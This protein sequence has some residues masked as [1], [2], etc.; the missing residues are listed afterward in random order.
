MDSSGSMKPHNGPNNYNNEKQFVK[1]MAEKLDIAPTGSQAAVIQ[2]SNDARVDIAF[3]ETTT[4]AEFRKAVDKLS[5]IGS[6][7]RI[8]RGLEKAMDAF[9]DKSEL[10]KLII[11]ITDGHQDR[12]KGKELDD[13]AQTLPSAGIEVIA[14]GIGGAVESE[15]A[16]VTGGDNSRNG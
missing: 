16:K 4:L 5:H 9:P 13:A 3:G 2:F 6:S 1:K 14:V 7:T 15:L 11:L 12:G 8:D 10:P